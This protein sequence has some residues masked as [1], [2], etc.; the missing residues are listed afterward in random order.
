MGKKILLLLLSIVL[1]A[2][3][4]KITFKDEKA[5]KEDEKI[6]EK[7][8]VAIRDEDVEKV[9][10]ILNEH[11]E[12]LNSGIISGLP[13]LHRAIGYNSMKLVKLFVL[14]GADVNG[15]SDGA[16]HTP[17]YKTARLLY[18][19]KTDKVL[20]I[21]K[22]M[23]EFL[24]SKGASVKTGDYYGN[25]PLHEAARSE[26]IE[27][28]KLFISEGTDVNTK[29]KDGETPLLSGTVIGG[30]MDVVE[31]LISKGA[32]VNVKGKKGYTPLINATAFGNNDV[33]ELLINNG[34]DVNARNS[35]GV[36]PLYNVVDEYAQD[37]ME[38]FVI[39]D[40]TLDELRKEITD[41]KKLK[42]LETMKDKYF[43]RN[44][45]TG[46][47]E[48]LSFNKQE[49]EIILNNTDRANDDVKLA[50][51]LIS[52]GASVNVKDKFGKTI[53]EVAK[54]AD[55]ETDKNKMK[56]LLLRNGAK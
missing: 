53:L 12:L 10:K 47:L 16:G 42:A 39:K 50:E 38:R 27:L 46:E 11:P 8:D 26:Q 37:V 25:T 48:K 55:R 31:L 19:D 49:I 33:S 22:E 9:E 5:E 32:I 13:P 52:K 36:T 44:E 43:R 14:K 23:A 20:A 24:I 41:S 1:L 4:N 51:L 2:G 29:N 21:R 45:L 3:C 30:E 56:E 7:F 18:Q 40:E 35:Y 34:A 17:L 54:E 15:R 6:R 28:I